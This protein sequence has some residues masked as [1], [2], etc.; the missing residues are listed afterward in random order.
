MRMAI[1][2]CDWKLS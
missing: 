2:G 1:S